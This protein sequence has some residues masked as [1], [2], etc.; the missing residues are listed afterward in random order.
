MSIDSLIHII[1]TAPQTPEA[2]WNYDDVMDLANMQIPSTMFGDD[3]PLL[4]GDQHRLWLRWFLEGLASPHKLAGDL[5]AGHLEIYALIFARIK[6]I[7][8]M[9]NLPRQKLLANKL[10]DLLFAEVQRLRQSI[11]RDHA[12]KATRVAL[13]STSPTP[14]CYICG[15]AFTKEA[16]DA[17]QQVQG[18]NPVRLPALVDIL[19]PRGLKERDIGIEIEH[20]VPVASG[21]SGQANLRLACGWCNMHKSSRTSLY[22]AAFMPPRTNFYLVGTHRLHELPHPFWTVRLLALK[23]KCQHQ[24]GCSVTSAD[25]ELFIAFRDWSGS[26]NPTN[27]AIYCGTHDPIAGARMLSASTAAALWEDRRR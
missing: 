6:Q 25:E 21:G 4:K 18:R 11:G 20:V 26:P 23:G 17:F 1:E 3:E 7:Y 14:R 15:Y 8:P 19:R 13:I 5:H 12:N 16:C 27:L 9:S 24:G 2:A 10:T 22:E